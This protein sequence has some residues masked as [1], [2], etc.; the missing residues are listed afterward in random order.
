M[1][2]SLLEKIG[3]TFKE[4]SIHTKRTIMFKE[5]NMLFDF[6][7][8]TP[9]SFSEYENA[10]INSNCTYKKSSSA[11][12][13]TASYLQELYILDKKFL[14]FKA[15]MYFW[16]REE[17]NK[18]FLA[19]ICAYARDSV[20]RDITPFVLFLYEGEQPSKA[21]L[22]DYINKCYPERF[23]PAMTASMGRNILSSWTQAGYL[24]GK[25][26]KVR[27]KNKPTAAIVSF[28]LLLS[29]LSGYRGES[30]FESNYFK[31]LDCT[32][33]QA[34]DVAK[35]ASRKG[36]IVFKHIESVVEV[37]FPAIISEDDLENLNE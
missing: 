6:V 29:Y 23:S 25:V 11:R 22:H 32:K 12:K 2:K 10:I 1:D 13:Y 19:F 37:D 3:F 15:F 8:T 24:K 35:Q 28:A 34:I 16:K 20:L 30:L 17:I 9:T 7:G 33:E 14:L 36:W 21:R 5:L 31:L 4:G 27:Q 26:K 18:N